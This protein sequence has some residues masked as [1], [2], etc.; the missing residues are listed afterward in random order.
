MDTMVW[1]DV[2]YA[3]ESM[4]MSIKD[5]KGVLF[6][7]IAI[8]AAQHVD[9]YYR[10]QVFH[11][12]M[13][14]EIHQETLHPR[15]EQRFVKKKEKKYV[16][17]VWDN[18]SVREDYTTA[19]TSFGQEQTHSNANTC[20][21]CVYKF[22]VL[23]YKRLLQY[24]NSCV[25]EKLT[26]Q[27]LSYTELK[28]ETNGFKEELRKGSFGAVYKGTLYKGKMLIAVKRLAKVVEEGEREF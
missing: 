8:E 26:I 16:K 2:L 14:E 9:K 15:F 4:P 19:T 20:C 10:K 12:D 1:G 21:N 17:L 25:T 13:L 5:C 6:W 3:D 27:L 11:L 28:N 7:R 24:G 23:K 22:R 18:S